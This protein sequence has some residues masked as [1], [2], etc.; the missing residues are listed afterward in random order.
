M[1]PF[2]EINIEEIN[3]TTPKK[4]DNCYRSEISYKG[5]DLIIISD[6]C[7]LIDNKLILGDDFKKFIEKL[8]SNNVDITFKNR[9]EWFNK[10]IPF[11][12]IN[13][14][15]K[16]ILLGNELEI[17]N[18]NNVVL[19]EECKLLLH[20]S[21]LKIQRKDF[22]LEIELLNIYH[23]DYENMEIDL[24]EDIDN[25]LLK[26]KIK[27]ELKILLDKK[28]EIENKIKECK[29]KLNN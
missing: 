5:D 25:I 2:Q 7:K 16:N 20:I 28:L 14:M 21:G 23:N 3:Y 27:E 6:N 1:I 15:Y 9:D 19:N 12:I 29:E 11:E 17:N 10:D 22:K 26:G 18:N 8:E 13:N 4:V 24:V